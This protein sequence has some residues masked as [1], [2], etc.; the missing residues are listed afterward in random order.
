LLFGTG[1]VEFKF[2]GVYRGK[3]PV[4]GQVA[5]RLDLLFHFEF[6][7]GPPRVAFLVPRYRPRSLKHRNPT[8]CFLAYSLAKHTLI[9]MNSSKDGTSLQHQRTRRDHSTETAEDYVEAV[10]EILEKKSVCRLVDLSS[11]F[12]VSHVTANRIVARLVKEKLLSTEPYQPILLTT[13]GKRMATSCRTRH[14]IVFEFLLSLGIDDQTA[15][16]DAEGIEHHVSPKTLDAFRAFT[17][18]KSV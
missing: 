17:R 2:T 8:R 5:H 4:G 3:P 10:A 12:G 16:L 15:R 14:E 13:K 18:S 6:S 1:R 7:D 9:S 11:Y